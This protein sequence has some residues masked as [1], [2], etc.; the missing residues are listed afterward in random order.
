MVKLFDSEDYWFFITL[1]ANLF[2]LLE[3]V[4][5][6]NGSVALFTLWFSKWYW[7]TEKA[8]QLQQDFKNNIN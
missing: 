2:L 5:K 6:P 1:K 8:N 7:D 3:S 4:F